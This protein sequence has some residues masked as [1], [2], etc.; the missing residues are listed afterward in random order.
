MNKLKYFSFVFLGFFLSQALAQESGED[1]DPA[2]LYALIETDHGVMEFEL[3]RQVAPVTVANFVNLA[4]RGFYNGLIFHRV[5]DDFMA[6]GG[7]PFGD[8]TGG[9]GYNFEDEIRMRH[10]QAGILSMANSGPD[11]NGSQFFITHLA[12]PHLNNLHTV[13]GKIISGQDI[14]RQIGRGDEIVSIR[15]EGN[16]QAFLERHADRLYQWNQILDDNFPDLEPAL[17]D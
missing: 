6:Q 13:F 5:I 7:D 2:G 3:Y 4:T 10:N 15:I 11:T 1:R 12:T 9:P 14:I 16:V 8:G 17:T